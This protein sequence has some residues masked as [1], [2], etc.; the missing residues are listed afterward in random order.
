[1]NRQ[2]EEILW[3]VAEET[4]EALA[5]LLPMPEPVEPFESSPEVAVS[6]RFHGPFDGKVIV[7]VAEL[8]LGELACNMLGLDDGAEI[9]VDTQQDALKELANVVCG[10]ILPEI[11][12]TTA[13][14][15]VDAPKLV[16]ASA[17]ASEEGLSLASETRFFLDSGPVSVELLT[18]GPI[19]VE[20]PVTAGAN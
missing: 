17:P 19:D 15:N 14:F 18:E 7:T 2:L 13:V 12:G 8:V 16:D 10:N 1:M 4:F 3:G 11:A 9:A 5:F 20:V 6:V